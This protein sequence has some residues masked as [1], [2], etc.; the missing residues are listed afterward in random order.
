[1]PRTAKEPIELK[2]ACVRAAHEVIAEHGIE[3]LS[4]REVARKLGVSH[5]APY[6]HYPTR[7]HLL[8]EVMRRCFEQFAVALDQREQSEDPSSDLR[9][10]G[11]A[12]LRFAATHPLEYRLMFNAPWPEK[13]DHPTLVRDATHA[14][15]ILR[16]VLSRVH[17]GKKAKKAAVDLD[18]MFIWSTMHGLASIMQSNA[19]SHLDLPKSTSA[20]A[21]PHVME[22]IGFA[23][24]GREALGAA[25]ALPSSKQPS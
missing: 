5:Q 13:A 14:F 21:Q 8:A 23:M 7:D 25:L 16:E 6:R 11:Q 20:K 10:L 17:G 19:M 1:M 2:E 15:D 22:M 3:A 12:Y 24:H 4:L 18:A 9:A